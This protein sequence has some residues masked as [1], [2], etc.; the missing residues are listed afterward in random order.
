[1]AE[2]NSTAVNDKTDRATLAA[3]KFADE[4]WRDCG[5]TYF[6]PLIGFDDGETLRNISGV[7]GFLHE[8][9]D[10]DES[11]YGNHRGVRLIVQ[12]AWAA[13]QYSGN[14]HDAIKNELHH[15]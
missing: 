4:T 6:N 2:S 14:L 8:I 1:M 12:T 5:P 9:L 15:G 13:A 10:S 7:L 11:N 3:T